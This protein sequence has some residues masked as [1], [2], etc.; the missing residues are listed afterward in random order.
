MR[1][2]AVD[3]AYGFLLHFVAKPCAQV[4]FNISPADIMGEVKLSN[5]IVP[6]YGL[7]WSYKII[8]GMI[9]YLLRQVPQKLENALV[10]PLVL[11][12][13]FVVHEQIDNIAVAVDFVYPLRVF[14]S[15]ERKFLPAFLREPE[16]NVI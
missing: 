9:Q 6:F 5:S 14:W 15:R 10:F 2:K 12:K 8:V 13:G 3:L 11:A 4:P 16:C 1:L 7:A